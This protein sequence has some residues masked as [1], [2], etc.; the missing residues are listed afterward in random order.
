MNSTTIQH[1][2]ELNRQFYQQTAADFHETRRQPWSGWNELLP[3][4][5]TPLSV[6][7]VGCGNGRFGHFLAQ[8]FGAQLHYHGIDNSPEL[9]AH[10]QKTLSTTAATFEL[11]PL[12]ILQAP[13]PT[14]QYDL[15]TLFGVLHHIPGY[16]QRE[17]LM[18]ELAECVKPGGLLAFACW[19]FY[20]S[21]R[22]RQRIITWPPEY[23]REDHDYL[24]DWQRGTHAIRYC[25]FVDDEEHAA[26][27][28]ATGLTEVKTYRAD[29]N[30]NR[31]SI[32]RSEPA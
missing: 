17:H 20:E 9:L 11:T 15:V 1:L 14:H 18:K 28:A 7:D 29:G 32:L 8:Q 16:A 3:F 30:L 25:H 31:Y 27:I 6:L 12:D 10:A 23:E 24:L 4:L 13:L 5:H 19:C 2:N 26:F 22:F 21:E